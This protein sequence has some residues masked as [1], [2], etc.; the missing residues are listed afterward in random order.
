MTDKIK[1]YYIDFSILS[2]AN[3]RR[4]LIKLKSVN[5]LYL[6]GKRGEREKGSRGAKASLQT[7]GS[8]FLIFLLNCTFIL[9]KALL[10][11][12]YT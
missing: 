3:L 9:V 5:I 6:I 2:T 1:G 11:R 8:N 7:S 10:N 4:N 12:D